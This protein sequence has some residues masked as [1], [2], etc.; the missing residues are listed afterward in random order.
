MLCICLLTISFLNYSSSVYNRE[1]IARND[2]VFLFAEDINKANLLVLI[3][4]ARQQGCYC[5]DNY[6]GATTPVKWSNELEQAAIA[7]CQDMFENN[8]FSHKSSNRSN[9]SD[10][11]ERVGYKWSICGENIGNGYTSEEQV[12][13]GWLSSPG[14]CVNIMNPKFKEMGVAKMGCYWT[15][16]FA[17]KPEW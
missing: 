14:H 3:N 12:V 13:A 10:R 17:S 6:F 15:Q 1:K 11:I 2:T 9:L 4:S 7:H 16:V 5:G 8:F